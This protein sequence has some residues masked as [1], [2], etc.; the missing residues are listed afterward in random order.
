MAEAIRSTVVVGM[1][2]TEVTAL[3]ELLDQQEDLDPRL[4]DLNNTIQAV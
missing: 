1:S 4:M 2:Q 3:A